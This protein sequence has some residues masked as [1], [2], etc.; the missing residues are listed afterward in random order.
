MDHLEIR[1]DGVTDRDW[2]E[3]LVREQAA[4]IERHTPFVT[5]C[6]VA[7]ERPNAHP[8]NGSSYRVRVEVRLAGADPFVVRREP[9]DG[10]IDD[11]VRKVIVDAFS[12]ADRKAREM[13]RQM[14][15]E[16]KRRDAPPPP[17]TVASELS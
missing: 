11:H 16:P 1:I 17:G 5:S 12:A 15:E 8:S 9:G 7:V 6:H 13:S 10:S 2:V 14:S 3:S 4:K